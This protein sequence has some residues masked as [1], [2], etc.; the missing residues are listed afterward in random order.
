MAPHHQQLD[1]I[2]LAWLQ[3]LQSQGLA[4]HDPGVGGSGKAQTDDQEHPRQPSAQPTQLPNTPEEEGDSETERTATAEDKRRRNTAA[5]GNFSLVSLKRWL[6]LPRSP[7]PE[8]EEAVAIEY[9]ANRH[10][11]IAS[12][13][14]LGARGG[15]L[16]TGERMAEGDR[17]AENAKVNW[18]RPG[19][20]VWVFWRSERYWSAG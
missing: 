17:D 14:R 11:S 4:Q 20:L 13:R 10:E 3:L 19:Q 15:R 6:I 18:R 16:A 5:S 8:Q 1:P 9:G 2:A 12:G 7:V